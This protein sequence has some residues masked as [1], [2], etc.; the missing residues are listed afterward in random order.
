MA[1]LAQFYPNPSR[2]EGYLVLQQLAM[3]Y[4][5]AAFEL[6]VSDAH[7]STVIVIAS[8]LRSGYS[9]IAQ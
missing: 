9:L 2:S 8:T 4:G 6:Q 7:P 5:A 3:K 1:S